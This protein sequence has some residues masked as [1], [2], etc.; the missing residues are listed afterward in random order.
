MENTDIQPTE[1]TMEIKSTDTF[2]NSVNLNY[3]EEQA[4]ESKKQLLLHVTLELIKARLSNDV[5]ITN[6]NVDVAVSKA[7]E[8]ID[9]VNK[10]YEK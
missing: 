4:A 10:R 5:P 7:Q 8:I 1:N 3:L 6:F 9:A 2:K